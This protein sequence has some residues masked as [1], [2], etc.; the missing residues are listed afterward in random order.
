M[1]NPH[2]RAAYRTGAS[3]SAMMLAMVLASPAE[4]ACTILARDKTCDATTTINI[5]GTSATDRATDFDTNL[6]SVT[7]T[8]TG[9][10]NGFGLAI[11]DS[12][13]GSPNSMTVTN[14]GSIQV[15]SSLVPSAGG[16]DG[17]MLIHGLDADYV[18]NGAG[19]I[20]NLGAGSGLQFLVDGTGTA[21]ADVGGNILSLN[22]SAINVVSSGGDITI[23]TATGKTLKAAGAGILVNASGPGAVAI[24]NRSDI[25]SSGPANTATFGISVGQL[26]GTGDVTITN[27]GAIGASGDRVLNNGIS[28]SSL[29]AASAG[30]IK[31]QGSGAI[32]SL[33]RGIDV[34]LLGTGLVDV[35][36][37]GSIDA[38]NG[39]AI[40]ILS[41]DA[42]GGD[43]TVNTVAGQT[44]KSSAG[45]G[46]EIQASGTGSAADTPSTTRAPS[47]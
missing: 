10:V 28:V 5:T 15:D 19:D 29:N 38:A 12:G 9:A 2:R 18:Y 6:G 3:L 41:N 47:M 24:T 17:A 13:A 30:D 11:T 16:S 7:L 21:D 1:K 27:T 39:D 23:A 42:A 22:A 20:T 44:L 14:N 40:Y 4:A 36:Y 8:V 43:I 25:S 34:Q 33:G 32:Y 46:I 26:T 35:N 37:S 31:V 45:N